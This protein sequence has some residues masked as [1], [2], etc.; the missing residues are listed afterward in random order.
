MDVR[1]ICPFSHTFPSK[2]TVGGEELNVSVLIN[3]AFPTFSVRHGTT[4]L[5]FGTTP[6]IDA[7]H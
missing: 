2:T 1:W 6:S 4:L 3:T 5:I 7:G